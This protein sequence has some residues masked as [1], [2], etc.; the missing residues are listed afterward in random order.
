MRNFL[1]L[2]FLVLLI[3]GC[4]SFTQHWGEIPEDINSKYAPGTD[5]QDTK[6]AEIICAS[7]ERQYYFI[8]TSKPS[9]KLQFDDE[10]FKLF[11]M[12]YDAVKLKPARRSF[13][14]HWSFLDRYAIFK[15]KNFEFKENTRYFAKYSAKRD[16]VKVWIEQEDGK[17]VYGKKPEQGQF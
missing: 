7:G 6:L 16:V 12:S 14:L 10:G 11:K 3:N 15:V 2:T 9:L 4:A 13:T 8:G 5:V 17:V 1:S